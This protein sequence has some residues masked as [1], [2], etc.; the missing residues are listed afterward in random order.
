MGYFY[1]IIWSH[2]Q[3]QKLFFASTNG[4]KSELIWRL[5]ATCP[6]CRQPTS[7][8]RQELPGFCT[9]SG[10]EAWRVAD[11]RRASQSEGIEERRSAQARYPR[12]G[13]RCEDPGAVGSAKLYN[14]YYN[15]DCK[16]IFWFF[17]PCVYF[18]YWRNGGSS[19][20]LS[21]FI[22]GIPFLDS[23]FCPSIFL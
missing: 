16:Q 9:A 19:F 18:N 12:F 13:R 5:P 21:N 10:A 22:F 15:G 2:C 1:F 23:L 3:W 17:R 7:W 6:H 4:L 11:F 20:R 8:S 14:K